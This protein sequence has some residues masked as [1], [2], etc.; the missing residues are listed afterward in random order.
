MSIFFVK[1]D[2]SVYS[3]L[4]DYDLDMYGNL[5]TVS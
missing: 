2:Q 1:N 5:S 3:G 4:L